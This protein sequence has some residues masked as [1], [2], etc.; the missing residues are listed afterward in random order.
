MTHS[1]DKT[2]ISSLGFNDSD[3]KT[4]EHEEACFNTISDYAVDQITK[5]LQ[6]TMF[7]MYNKVKFEKFELEKV[8]NQ[9]SGSY[10]RTI[11]FIDIVLFYKVTREG[12]CVDFPTM[13][14]VEV[15]IG[16]TNIT[17]VIRQIKFYKSY[18]DSDNRKFILITKYDISEIEKKIIRN[19]NIL[20]ISLKSLIKKEEKESP[21][22]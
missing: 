10:C 9:S 15:K 19:E 6:E 1:H 8:L 17:D 22:K 21:W 3:K 11:G 16:K 18:L 20:W 14:N 4:S 2:Y 13:V 5:F 7:N 12:R